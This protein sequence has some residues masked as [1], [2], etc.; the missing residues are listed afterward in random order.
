MNRMVSG[1]LKNQTKT[2]HQELEK[3]FIFR[4]RSLASVGDYT[5]M[6]KDLYGF[7]HPLEDRISFHISPTGIVPDYAYRRKSKD[8]LN[9]IFSLNNNSEPNIPLSLHEV[10]L[11]P[12]HYHALG[13]LYVLEGSTLG[14]SIICKMIENKLGFTNK[15]SLSYF[16]SYGEN[17]TEMWEKF[18]NIL[19]DLPL[20]DAQSA[21]VIKGANNTFNGLKKWMGYGTSS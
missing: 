5:T 10:P 15:D 16:Y 7:L 20:D 14:G 9:D 18:K 2:A 1:A 21:E 6:L 19:D 17:T 3:I 11:I 8:L 4:I 12:D 13:A